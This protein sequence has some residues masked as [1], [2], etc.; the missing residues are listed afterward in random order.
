MFSMM[1]T[2]NFALIIKFILERIID[3]TI[4]GHNYPIIM[5]SEVKVFLSKHLVKKGF[6]LHKEYSDVRLK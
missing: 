1:K 4:D 3:A 5:E 2:V 6:F